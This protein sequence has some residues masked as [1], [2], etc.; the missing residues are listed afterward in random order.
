MQGY[1]G[2]KRVK[3]SV[4]IDTEISRECMLIKKEFPS[5]VQI[6]KVMWTRT[7]ATDCVSPTSYTETT[8][9]VRKLSSTKE[10][11]GSTVGVVDNDYVSNCNR[12]QMRD[13]KT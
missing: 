12:A 5:L 2:E 3:S 10:R 7:C 11:S 4:K 6:K 8:F 13:S 1:S 9:P